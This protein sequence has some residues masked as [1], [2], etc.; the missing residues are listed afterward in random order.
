MHLNVIGTN[1]VVGAD[2]ILLLIEDQ[3]IILLPVPKV[4]V[5]GAVQD[6][7]ALNGTAIW[8]Y[9]INCIQSVLIV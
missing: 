5:L 6:W 4:R 3:S 2:S 1:L 7:K 9:F 8:I